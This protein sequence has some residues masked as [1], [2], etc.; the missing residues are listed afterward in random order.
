VGAGVG[1]TRREIRSSRGSAPSPLPV[2]QI[3]ITTGPITTLPGTGGRRCPDLLLLFPRRYHHHRGGAGEWE[4]P[5]LQPLA[6]V[7]PPL[8][9]GDGGG[10][11]AQVLQGLLGTGE[12]ENA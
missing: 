1:L 5:G 7:R 11:G 9:G 2:K 10:A 6:R 12:G 8:P 4:L 3:A